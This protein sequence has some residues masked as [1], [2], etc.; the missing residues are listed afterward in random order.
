MSI[1]HTYQIKETLRGFGGLSVVEQMEWTAAYVFG[2]G[3]FSVTQSKVI[4]KAQGY[5]QTLRLTSYLSVAAQTTALFQTFVGASTLRASTTQEVVVGL[6]LYGDSVF[7][8]ALG[9]LYR[10]QALFKG[11]GKFTGWLT[12]PISAVPDIL[13]G[14]VGGTLPTAYA[15]VKSAYYLSGS[16][17]VIVRPRIHSSAEAVLAGGADLAVDS[18]AG[19]YQ[20]AV[21][22]IGGAYSVFFT[23]LSGYIT[24]AGYAPLFNAVKWSVS[25]TLAVEASALYLFTDQLH[26]NI[27]KRAGEDVLYQNATG[28]EK[29]LAD[30]D[31]YRLTATYAELVRDQWDP[32]GIARENLAHLAWASGVNLWE[33][34]WDETFRRLWVSKQ[35][36]LKYIRGSRLG[37]DEF[38]R[39]VGGIV[40]RCIVPPAK[41]YPL[42]A[43]TDAEWRAYIAKFPQLR[44]YPYVARVPLKFKCYIPGKSRRKP[45]PILTHEIHGSHSE[46]LADARVGVSGVFSARP[47]A[48]LGVDAVPDSIYWDGSVSPAQ[49]SLLVEAVTKAVALPKSLGG[50]GGLNAMATSDL[51]SVVEVGSG[52]LALGVVRFTRAG[53]AAIA[54][55]GG[56]L[57]RTTVIPV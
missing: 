44:M 45:Y 9:K 25:S 42:P 27:N 40:K 35:W 10:G 47:A 57:V 17:E 18:G 37:L 46:L 33:D 24:I 16:G 22:L 13:T 12:R 32:F 50:S 38:V 41:T 15:W 19:R 30:T 8:T 5:P 52:S 26:P 14:V 36:Y 23:N 51:V 2:A 53:R 39:A 48:R 55:S 31:A 1:H 11:G 43:I 49:S 4:L 20:S 54:G 29:A 6:E 28:L 3:A 7:Y 56:M 21:S 34:Y